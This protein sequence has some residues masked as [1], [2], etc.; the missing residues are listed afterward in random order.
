M[1]RRIFT[2]SRRK[3][4]MPAIRAFNMIEIVKR[5]AQ[6]RAQHDGPATSSSAQKLAIFERR[7]IT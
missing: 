4:S 1:R 5:V 7:S 6:F 3:M 2:K